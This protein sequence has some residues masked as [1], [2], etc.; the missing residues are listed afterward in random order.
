MQQAI[1]HTNR[2]RDALASQE[3]SEDVLKGRE[4][5]EAASNAQQQ[6]WFTEFRKKPLLL[7]GTELSHAHRDTLELTQVIQAPKAFD[8]LC[9]HVYMKTKPKRSAVTRL[10]Q[11][12]ELEK[13]G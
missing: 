1:E 8:A 6:T 5:F 12:I 3:R 7:K 9:L 2:V 4:A 13:G 10:Q 11:N